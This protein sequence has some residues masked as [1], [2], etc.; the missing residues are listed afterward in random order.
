MGEELEDNASI[1]R[2]T[3]EKEFEYVLAHADAYKKNFEKWDILGKQTWSNP[4]YLIKII[5]WEAHVEYVRNYL[6]QSLE[7]LEY[8]Y[9]DKEK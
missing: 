2:A 7:Y 9:C 4:E 6:E 8:V 3:L 1:I 5:T